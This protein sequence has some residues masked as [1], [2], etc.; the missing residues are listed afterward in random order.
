MSPCSCQYLEAACSAKP[1]PCKMTTKSPEQAAGA[2]CRCA[3]ALEFSPT[4]RCAV[5]D[6]C[7]PGAHAQRLL[8]AVRLHGQSRTAPISI[9]AFLTFLRSAGLCLTSHSAT[10]YAYSGT[11]CAPAVLLNADGEANMTASPSP[12]PLCAPCLD[13]PLPDTLKPDQLGS[14][15]SNTRDSEN[16]SQNSGHTDSVV[17]NI[18]GRSTEAYLSDTPLSRSAVKSATPP[19]LSHTGQHDGAAQPSRLHVYRNSARWQLAGGHAVLCKPS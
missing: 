10:R 18:V 12:A 6:T 2:C 1:G 9:V 14:G 19:V 8:C 16:V 15:A 4:F 7:V 5:A 3:Q 17:S 13:S 11:L